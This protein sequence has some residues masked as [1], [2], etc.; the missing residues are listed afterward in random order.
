[1]S[2]LQLSKW[3]PIKVRDRDTVLKMEKIYDRQSIDIK[4]PVELSFHVLVDKILKELK[5]FRNRASWKLISLHFSF[6]VGN[7][8]G[9]D[10]VYIID[11]SRNFLKRIQQTVCHIL[12]DF[13]NHVR[14]LLVERNGKIVY[15]SDCRERGKMILNKI[16]AF[17]ERKK[18]SV[19]VMECFHS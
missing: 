15:F 9:K 6:C 8:I 12:H 14:G 17:S 1:M 5:N 18:R 16:N 19:F 11:L 2:F 4:E 7:Q 13:N 10:N 3:A